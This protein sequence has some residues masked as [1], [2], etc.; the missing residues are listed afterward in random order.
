VPAGLTQ[1]GACTEAGAVAGPFGDLAA[2]RYG[3]FHTTITVLEAL[4]EYRA[5]VDHTP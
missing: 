2:L 5:T 3:S 4:L 1:V